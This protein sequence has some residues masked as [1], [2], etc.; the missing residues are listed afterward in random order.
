[1]LDISCLGGNDPQTTHAA[2][3]AFSVDAAFLPPL[4]GV[5]NCVL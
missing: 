2:A 1:M 5:K 3:C 4:M